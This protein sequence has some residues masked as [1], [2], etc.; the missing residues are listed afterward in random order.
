MPTTQQ[1]R[2]ATNLRAEQESATLYQMLSAA[3]R[4]QKLAEVYH[5][6]AEMEQRHASVWE[7]KLRQDGISPDPYTPAWR[8]RALGW[9]AHRFGP[10]VVLPIVSSMERDAVHEYD[11]QPEAR[12][13]G[14]VEEERSHARV[15]SY[16]RTATRGGITGS[17][18]AQLEGRHRN[19]GGGNALRAAVLGASD[20][21]TSNLSLV[22]G[23]AGAN[24]SGRAIL[25]TG[26][27]G[28]LA[29]ALSMAIG[30]WLSVQSSRELFERQI[31]IERDELATAP[32]EEREELALIYE[33][34]GIEPQEAQ[35][36]AGNILSDKEAA[37]DTLAREELG[38]DPKELGGSAW[39]A[40]IASFLLFSLGALIPVLPFIFASGLGAVGISLGL[41]IIGLFLIGVGISLTTGV[42]VLRSG[43]RQVIMGMAAAGIT[44]GLG[45]LVGGRLG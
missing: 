36:L 31:A 35:R 14:M 7:S 24:L 38:I 1:Q 42:S 29:G 9:L 11:S 40:S 4:D 33:A 39:E 32:E 17:A 37:L 25:L 28:L 43:P 18:L 12:A 3:E 21:L 45:R 20:G 19:T 27:A 30:E 16:L 8:I 15:F 26:I 13:A 34:K 41:S 2:Y 5:R 44:F 10:G 22:M 6:M 23:V